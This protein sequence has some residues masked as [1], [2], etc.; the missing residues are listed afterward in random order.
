MDL[1]TVTSLR[2]ARTRADLALGAGERFLAGGSWLFSE[3]QPGTTGLVDLTTMG[4]E[5]WSLTADGLS[6]AATC[7][8]AELRVR[9]SALGVPAAP[10][11]GA[12][13]DAFL[14][15][16]KIWGTATVG[17][18][19]ALALPAGSMISLAVALDAEAVVWTPDGGER[20]QPV[21]ELVTGPGTTTLGPGEVLRSVE[22]GTAALESRTAFRKTALTALGR[23]S[24]VVTG[25]LGAGGATVLTVT[26]S[27]PRPHVL[28]FDALPGPAELGAALDGIDAWYDD[29][30][31]AP[32]WRAAVTRTLA[33]EVVEELG[34]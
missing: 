27:T 1:D 28:A 11:F 15:S 14:M 8:V 16:F 6:I 3:P 9:G 4:W 2:P 5:P 26:A 17:G 32:D 21:S 34:R 30:H 12:C 31:G 24:A 29:P 7:T 22:I 19:V 20:R 25:R 23:S 33:R 10:L 13:V 18:N